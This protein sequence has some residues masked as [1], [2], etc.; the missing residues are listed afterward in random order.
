MSHPQSFLAIS[1]WG[2]ST[3]YF[4]ST[5]PHLQGWQ[6]LFIRQIIDWQVGLQLNRPVQIGCSCKAQSISPTNEHKILFIS[7]SFCG[8]CTSVCTHAEGGQR[9]MLAIFLKYSLPLVF[10]GRGLLLNLELTSSSRLVGQQTPGYPSFFTYQAMILQACVASPG[11]L[12][13]CCGSKL[14]FSCLCGKDSTNSHLPIP[15]PLPLS[16]Y[17]QIVQHQEIV[18]EHQTSKER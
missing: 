9:S 13:E 3:L 6:W 5:A 16:F 17:L 1:Q 10:W 4:S 12:S 14:R 7:S 15:V 18:Q 11:F 2:T 8:T